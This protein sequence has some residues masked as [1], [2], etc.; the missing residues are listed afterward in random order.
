MKRLMMLG[1]LVLVCLFLPATGMS[2]FL[3]DLLKPAPKQDADRP[4]QERAADEQPDLLEG[5]GGI[6]G[7]KK[8]KIDLFKKGIGVVEALDRRRAGSAAISRNPAAWCRRSS[9]PQR[10]A[11]ACC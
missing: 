7:V 3:D 1:S 4:A 5:I 9:F 2:G 11:A 6:F 10:S 8:N